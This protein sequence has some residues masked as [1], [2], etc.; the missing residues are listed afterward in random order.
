MLKK[1]QG[2]LSLSI[3]AALALPGLAVTTTTASADAFTDALT[4][5]GKV[6]MD[7]RL[8]FEDVEDDRNNAGVKLKDADALTVRTRL[9]Y[10]TGKYMDFD[11]F[12]E[13]ENV[14][15]I[16]DDDDYNTGGNGWGNGN[17]TYATIADPAGTEVNRYWLGY[18][19]IDDTV[20]R[21]GRQRIK[22]D[23]DRHI[24]NVGWR[25]NEQTYDSLTITNKSLPDTKL[26]YAY[27]T[28]VNRIFGNG[29]N[30]DFGMNS[31]LFNAAYDGLG[32]GK[33]V[34]YGY[35]LDYENN[36]ATQARELWSSQTL[37][38]RFTGDTDVGGGFKVHYQAEYAQQEDYEEG[39]SNVATDG[40]DIDYDYMMF[41]L[42]VTYAGV[43]AMAGYEEQEGDRTGAFTTRLATLHG[44]NGWADMFLSGGRGTPNCGL[45]DTSFSLST[46]VGGVKLKAVYHDYEADGS[47]S[48]ARANGARGSDYGD[49]INLVAVK[50]FGKHYHALVKYARFSSDD[51]LEDVDK[52]WIQTGFK[53]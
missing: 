1:S 39:A 20:A 12:V 6:T 22:L 48:C 41:K 28:N 5:G 16:G 34:A 24:G 50:K 23:N 40:A 46:K 15:A 7:V 38:L 52:L 14:T 19:G 37:G 49:E 42:G 18:S 10:Q 32:F 36:G 47:S 4:T 25:Q 17:G 43:T 51:Y 13:M 44:Q 21:V 3:A 29:N 35:F 27:I 45:Q 9:G 53:F 2:L 33:I 30:G 8:R 11:A 26:F 31:H